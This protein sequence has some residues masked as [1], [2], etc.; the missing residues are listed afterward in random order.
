MINLFQSLSRIQKD[1]SCK[2]FP[3]L[4]AYKEDTAVLSFLI[5]RRTAVTSD[6]N[7]VPYFVCL[8]N[9][10]VLFIPYWVCVNEIVL[11]K[12]WQDRI[13]FFIEELTIHS[14]RIFHTVYR[15]QKSKA[16]TM[17]N[18]NSLRFIRYSQILIMHNILLVKITIIFL[19]ICIMIFTRNKVNGSYRAKK[20]VCRI[21]LNVI[22]DTYLT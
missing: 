8:N 18:S 1:V 13:F 6:I 15:E 22:L 3:A 2:H 11:F 5:I 17:N 21:T 20:N 10:S 14:T 9:Y 19:P 16:T 12:L 4:F 7:W